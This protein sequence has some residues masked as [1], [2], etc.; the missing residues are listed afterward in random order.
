MH[1]QLAMQKGNDFAVEKMQLVWYNIILRWAL[2]VYD[3]M[4]LDINGKT[5]NSDRKQN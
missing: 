1:V 2:N 5:E 4:S 3:E